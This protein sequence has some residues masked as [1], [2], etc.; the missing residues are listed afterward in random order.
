MHRQVALQIIKL[1]GEA[2]PKAIARCEA[3]FLN[4][5][6]NSLAAQGKFTEA[7]SAHREDLAFQRR[8]STN[9]APELAF[10]LDNL[11]V[12]FA[13]QRT[14]KCR[15]G[16][17]AGRFGFRFSDPLLGC[18]QATELRRAGRLTRFGDGPAPRAVAI[19]ATEN[20]AALDCKIS[21]PLG[22]NRGWQRRVRHV[23]YRSKTTSPW[24]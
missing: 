7:A 23:K 5:L 19:S 11:A 22:R 16:S 10:S 3:E 24:P 2:H 15:L 4:H 21:N 8:I 6:G 12:V 13:R 9:N 17:A 1:G 18:R 14:T 20:P